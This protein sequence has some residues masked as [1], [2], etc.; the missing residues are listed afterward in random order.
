MGDAAAWSSFFR[1]RGWFERL[2]QYTCDEPPLTCAWR[3]IPGIAA[4]A[5][6][7][8]P[9]LRTLVTTTI[10]E[11]DDWGVTSSIDL[12]VPVINYL[13]DKSGEFAGDQR[14]K[15]DA[16]AAQPRHEVWSYQSCMSH[17]CGGTVN[18]GSPSS[19]DQYFTGWPS[20]MIDASAPRNRAMQ[21]LAFRHRLAGELYYETAM[22][23]THSPWTNQWDFSGNGDGT[24][25]YPGTPSRIGGATHVPVASIRLKMIREGM[26]DYEYLA[27]LSRL[28]GDAEAREIAT[29][30]FPRAFQTEVS[31][32]RLMEARAALAAAI[33]ARS[34]GID[35]GPAPVPEPPRGPLEDGPPGQVPVRGGC[36]GGPAGGLSA[37]ALAAAAI[38]RARRRG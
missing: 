9:E 25:F 28:G 6:A 37:L 15:Y 3:D 23:Y 4:A 5:K 10:Q 19:S 13:D 22:A 17:G 30:L 11:A 27:L 1:P 14:A 7:A 26:E 24:L 31:P 35:P 12:L 16:F 38:L 29:A 18:F 8:D 20:Y 33:V 2:F 34:G 21:W 32:A 36:G